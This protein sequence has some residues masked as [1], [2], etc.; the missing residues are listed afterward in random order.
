MVKKVIFFNHWHNGDIHVSRGIVRK[1]INKVYAQDPSISFV[2]SHKNDPNLLMDIPNLKFDPH[3][4]NRVGVADNLVVIDDAVYINTWYARNNFLYVNQ[5]GITIDALYHSFSD[6]CNAFWGFTLDDISTNVSD[7]F[8]VIDYSCYDT[9]N[10]NNWLRQNSLKKV[11]VENGNAMSSQATNFPMA[12]IIGSL[13]NKHK[14]KIFIL[15]KR[16]NMNLPSNVIYTSDIIRKQKG[17]DLNEI[18]FLS[19]HCNMIIGRASGVFSFTLTKENLFIRDT[20]FLCFTNLPTAVPNKFWVGASLN[21][22]V[23]YSANIF[24]TNE[25]NT[26]KV[27]E[28]IDRALQ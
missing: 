20:K 17:S 18:S 8:P 14:D 2:Y 13:A 24:T 26:I 4:L 23:E 7:F 25:S 5:Y 28:I 12:P 16:E 6:T 9:A 1:I 3:A 10:A 11:L 27:S 22:R 19:T 15:S 21:N